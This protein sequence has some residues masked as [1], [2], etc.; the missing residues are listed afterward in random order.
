MFPELKTK[1]LTLRQF[2]HT[3]LEPLCSHINNFAVS[4]MLAEVPHPY[5]KEDGAWWIDFCQ[6]TPLS[7][8]IAWVI[9]TPAGFSGAITLMKL[10]SD[11]PILGYWLAEHLWG[12]GYVS[13]AAEAVVSYGFKT[14]GLPVIYSSAL[15]ENTASLRILGKLGFRKPVKGFATPRS[16]GGE[17][18]ADISVS[19]TQEQWATRLAEA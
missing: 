10:N 5:T 8:K 4:K 7:E 13:E 6:K 1:S 15:E 17:S 14:L 18:L 9:E 3:D 2:K 12:K 19:L 16:R 11:K